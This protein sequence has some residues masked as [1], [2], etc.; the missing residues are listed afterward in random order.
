MDLET[1]GAAATTD[2]IIEVGIIEVDEDGV[3]EWSQLVNPKTRIPEF[4]EYLTGITNTMVADQPTFAEIAREVLKRLCGRLFI[5]HNARFDYGFLKNEFKRA[6]LDFR[7]TVLC[8]VKLSRR[9]YPQYPRHNLDVLVA[10]HGLEVDSRHRALGDARL[11]HQL[12]ARLHAERPKADIVAAVQTLTTCPS[13]PE[14]LNPDLVDD[15][16]EGSG[17]YLF[18]GENDLPLYVGKAKHLRRRV[19]AHF[20]R[21]HASAK[22]MVLARQVRRIDWLETGGEIGALLKEAV[23]VK[24]LQPLHNRR[25]R[26]SDDLC[27]WRLAKC[28]AGHF[29]LELAFA[30]NLDLSHQ[31]DLYGLFKNPRAATHALVELADKQGLCRSVL[32]LEH[33]L[34]DRPCFAYQ[35]GKCRGTCIGREALSRHSARLM[36][37]LASWKIQSWPFAGPA[38][39]QEGEEAHVINNWCYVGT[40]RTEADLHDPLEGGVPRFDPDIY[41]LLV[42]RLP[43]MRPLKAG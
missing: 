37:A 30:R 36:T 21:D 43:H 41:K 27:A 14:H 18:Y 23:L 17:V 39:L 2:R 16:P 13:L 7:A 26:H 15:L 25:L 3:R 9:L 20:A 4:I 10:R 19:L 32:G 40:L 11:I 22:A 29:A 12:W 31:D 38:F 34:S 1:T 42:R 24:T 28:E 35:L 8:T 33:S 6:G 5:A